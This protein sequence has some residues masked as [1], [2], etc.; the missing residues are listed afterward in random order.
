M[1]ILVWNGLVPFSTV[2]DCVKKEKL[3]GKYKCIKAHILALLCTYIV[4]KVLSPSLSN[5]YDACYNLKVVESV[6]KPLNSA[7]K[8]DKRTV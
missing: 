7:D 3:F 1:Q 4:L 5:R 2:W 8:T 6:K